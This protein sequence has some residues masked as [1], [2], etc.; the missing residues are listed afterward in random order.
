MVKVWQLDGMPVRCSRCEI[1]YGRGTQLG[2][3]GLFSEEP[4]SGPASFVTVLDGMRGDGGQWIPFVRRGRGRDDTKTGHRNRRA[5][6][7]NDPFVNSGPVEIR[8]DRCGNPTRTTVRRLAEL[9]RVAAS[10]GQRV[11]WI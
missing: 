10:R 4:V 3:F 7:V 9:A 2:S 8:C 5:A 11:L 6:N 1:K